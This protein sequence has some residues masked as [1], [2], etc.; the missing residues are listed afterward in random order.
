MNDMKVLLLSQLLWLTPLTTLN[1]NCANATAATQKEELPSFKNQ[2]AVIHIYVCSRG[3][4]QY[5]LETESNGKVL[6][7]APDKLDDAFKKDNTAVIFTGKL[8]NETV[9]IKK[10][11]PTDVPVL[12]FKAPKV[13]IESIKAVE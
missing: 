10:T 11:S 7:M 3:C 13:L 8:T 6:K 12:N 4:Y 2:K 5:V 1:L 9:D